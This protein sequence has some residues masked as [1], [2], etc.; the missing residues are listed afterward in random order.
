MKVIAVNGSPRHG[1]NT[2]TLL[3]SAL[4]GARSQGAETEIIHLYDLRFKGCS[5]C[6]ACKRA[7]GGNTGHCVLKDEL[8]V[9]LEKIVESDALILGSPVYFGNMTGSM[10]CLLER[11]LFSNHTYSTGKHFTLDKRFPIGF[12]Y[13]MNVPNSLYRTTH[14]EIIF[15][16]YRHLLEMFGGYSEFLAVTDTYQFDDY[17]KYDASRF[18]VAHK[19]EVRTRQFPVDLK[20]AY[21]LGARLV[22]EAAK[23]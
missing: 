3:R 21:K 23:D 11:L 16:Y 12:I 13:T 10:V 17:S 15:E 4:D 2:D 5:S 1:W 9:C 18:N 8:S 19:E 7:G 6:F 20:N 14:Y 22:A